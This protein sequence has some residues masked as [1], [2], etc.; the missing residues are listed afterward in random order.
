M[1]GLPGPHG[2][3]EKPAHL[4]I[5][6]KLQIAGFVCRNRPQHEDALAGQGRK[7]TWHH[8]GMDFVFG[9]RKHQVPFV[10]NH[11]FDFL[12]QH[13]GGE[14]IP[15]DPRRNHRFCG[16]YVIAAGYFFCR[17]CRKALSY[18]ML[19]GYDIS[20]KKHLQ[21]LGAVV[22]IEIIIP[23]CCLHESIRW[24]GKL[25]SAIESIAGKSAL[26]KGQ[27]LYDF[28]VEAKER[29]LVS[30]DFRIIEGGQLFLCS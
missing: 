3:Q 17:C 2:I 6:I 11:R 19:H 9:N 5:Q 28:P 22:G 18:L 1:V 23:V 27:S 16:H 20:G 30:F 7:A 14:E 10:K 21:R 24:N 13:R 25:I 12:F 8:G 15:A 29:I 4:S 26:T